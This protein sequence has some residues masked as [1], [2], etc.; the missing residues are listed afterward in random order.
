MI[1]DEIRRFSFVQAYNQ[2][3][4]IEP[5]DSIDF[6]LTVKPLKARLIGVISQLW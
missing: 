5:E 1:I 6:R 4:N 3:A 2:N